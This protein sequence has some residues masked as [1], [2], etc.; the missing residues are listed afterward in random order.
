VTEKGVERIIESPLTADELISM[1]NS[2]NVL[3][4]ALDSL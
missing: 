4:K 2:A 3:R 1:S